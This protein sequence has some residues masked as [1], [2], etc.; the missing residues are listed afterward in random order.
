MEPSENKT[1]G[2]WQELYKSFI[3]AN[4]YPLT[5]IG[6]ISAFIFFATVNDWTVSIKIIFPI[7]GTLILSIIIFANMSFRMHNRALKKL[8]AVIQGRTPPEIGGNACALILL[9]T[10]EL[11]GQGGLASVYYYD[12][13]LELLIGFGFVLTIQE[14]GLIQVMVTSTFDD[15]DS[16][17]KDIWGKVRNN[18]K[19]IL[20]KILVKPSIPEF[21]LPWR[22]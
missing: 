9:E 2:F 15:G 11:F 6:F 7:A 16:M 13:G 10:S 22:F 20:P 1:L 14:D 17:Q 19:N 4:G 12:D 18:N 5:F 3:W 8:P 21:L